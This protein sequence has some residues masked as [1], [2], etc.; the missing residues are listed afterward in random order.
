MSIAVGT[1]VRLNTSAR[2]LGEVVSPAGELA[3]EELVVVAFPHGREA[4][5]VSLLTVV[6]PNTPGFNQH[7]EIWFK[8]DRRG[9]KQA[10]YWSRA[11]M[12]AFRLP[13]ADAE[14]FVAQDQATKVDGHPFQP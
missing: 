8:N 7:L 2:T 10:W 11:A 1:K 13:L 4:V 12:R 14:L 3:N 5:H 6:R 9:R